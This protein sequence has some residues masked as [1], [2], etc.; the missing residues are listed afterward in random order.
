MRR[1]TPLTIMLLWSALLPEA[2]AAQEEPSC[3]FGQTIVEQV[4]GFT[5]RLEPVVAGRDVYECRALVQS[6]R[7]ETALSEVDS[8]F[9]MNPASGKDLNGDG[10]PELVLEGYSGGAHCCWTYWIVSLGNRPGLLVAIYNERTVAFRDEDNDGSIEMWTLDGVFDYFDGLS[11]AESFFPTVVLRLEGRKLMDVSA[12]YWGEY[13]GQI[14]EARSKLKAE[15]LQRFRNLPDICAI[16]GD[17][18]HECHGDVPEGEFMALREVK[19][20]VSTIVLGYLYSGR[21]LEAWKTLDDMWPSADKER[22]KRE[23]MNARQCGVL[24][25]VYKGCPGKS[26]PSQ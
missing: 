5:V 14:S 17:E 24:S 10:Q 3:H 9:K 2:A 18:E 22:T 7:G 26:V 21:E 12:E 13:E 16:G 19:V 11:H 20:L 8:W 15:S 1:L 23:F 4:A 25:Y 6:P